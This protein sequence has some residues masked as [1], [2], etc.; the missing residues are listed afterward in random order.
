MTLT[1]K[2]LEKLVQRAQG[3]D[4]TAFEQLY[5]ATS[6][7]QRYLAL[8]YLK[9]ADAADEAVQE[10]YLN[11]YRKLPQIESGR[12][13][14]A[15]LNHTTYFVCQNKKRW[16]QR[17]RDA[18]VQDADLEG[19]ESS[20]E[21]SQPELSLQRKERDRQLYAALEALPDRQRAAILLRYFKNCR[22]N[23]VAEILSVSRNTVLRDLKNAKRQLRAEMGDFFPAIFPL[24]ICLQAAL[25]QDAAAIGLG[26]DQ[27]KTGIKARTALAACAV[28]AVGAASIGALLPPRITGAQCQVFTPT[29]ASITARV[30]GPQIRQVY[31]TTAG[32]H[33]PMSRQDGSYVVTATQN[34]CYTITAVTAAGNKTSRQVMVTGLDDEPPQIVRWGQQEGYISV[35]L[36]D[37]G[38][39]I[40]WSSVRATGDDGTVFFSSQTDPASGTVLLALPL[41]N[42]CLEATDLAGNRVSGLLTVQ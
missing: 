33:L 14:V 24:G 12:S 7:A 3:G 36:T 27:A 23:E 38:S 6:S 29:T 8:G 25:R 17:Q 13:V 4:S 20:E 21:Q 19:L 39:G 22:I 2:E 10:V 5:R 34:G 9:D 1:H 18:T 15:Y 37:S 16:W 42:Y 28:A 26:G 35:C 32:Q 40:D 41:G 30:Q 31:V 11:L